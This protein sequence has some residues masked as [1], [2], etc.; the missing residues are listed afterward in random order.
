MA[1]DSRKQVGGLCYARAEAVSHDAKRIYGASYKETWVAGTVTEVVDHRPTGS[2]R[3]TTYIIAKYKIGNKEYQKSIPLQSLKSQLPVAVSTCQTA[4]EAGVTTTTRNDNDE[5]ENPNTGGD[6]GTPAAAAAVPPAANNNTAATTT[7]PSPPTPPTPVAFANDGRAWFSGDTRHD[8]NGPT[9]VKM[10][11]M[12]CQWTGNEYT[13]GCDNGTNPKYN[14]L[15]CFMATFPKTQLNWMVQALSTRLLQDGKDPSTLGELLKWFGILILITRFEY[16]NRAE[17]WSDT[18]R[19][20]YIPAPD[21]GKTGMSRNRWDDI[22]RCM[23]WSDQPFPCPEGMSSEHHRWLLVQDFVDR[24]NEHRAAYFHPS[25][26]I[27]VDESISRWYGLG[28]SWIN[29]GLPHYVAMDRKPEDGAEIQ[30]SCC[31][32]SNIMMRLKLVKSTKEEE[33]TR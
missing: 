31:G 1:P 28:G 23:V 24:V 12:T 29:K 13:E 7:T 22:W 27:C 25:D 21:F 26:I 33:A 4:A 11:K 30:D 10:W 14:E 19:C 15:D 6:N 9:P 32:K 20:K 16:G 5:N 17:L 2:K 3:N 18:P 8:V